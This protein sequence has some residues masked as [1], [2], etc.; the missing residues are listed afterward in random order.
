MNLSKIQNRLEIEY[1]EKCDK[2]FIELQDL[3]DTKIS[4]VQ[5][6]VDLNREN[7]REFSFEFNGYWNPSSYIGLTLNDILFD[8]ELKLQDIE[9]CNTEEEYLK[10]IFQCDTIFINEPD[11]CM[12]YDIHNDELDK[13]ENKLN[14]LINRIKKL[15]QIKKDKEK[16]EIDRQKEKN[17][18]VLEKINQLQI[19]IS[20]LKIQITK[21]TKINNL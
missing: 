16:I 4:D 18:D 21:S 3:L 8:L 2:F 15:I 9:K 10:D 5:K 6:R 7:S 11:D 17:D 14:D 20:E 19:Q 12:E 1:S 13:I